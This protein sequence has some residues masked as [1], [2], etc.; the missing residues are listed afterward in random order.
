MTRYITGVDRSQDTMFPDTLDD[1]IGEENSVRVIDI[2]VEE[3]DLSAMGFEKAAPATTGRPAYHP[4]ALLKLNI[5]SVPTF[6]T[7]FPIIVCN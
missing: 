6:R 5:S 3:L 1:Y 4:S 7:N 2:F